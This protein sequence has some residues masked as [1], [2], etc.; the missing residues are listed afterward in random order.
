VFKIAL[1]TFGCNQILYEWGSISYNL[2][3]SSC[4][5]NIIVLR[6]AFACVVTLN[7]RFAE[8]YM[9]FKFV[10]TLIE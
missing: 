6:E 4:V 7:F 3:E 9:N 1:G 5:A 8:T 10:F 2:V